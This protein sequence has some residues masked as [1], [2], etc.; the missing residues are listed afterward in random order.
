[1]RNDLLGPRTEAAGLGVDEEELLLHAEGE[2]IA[3]GHATGFLPWTDHRDPTKG[4][5]ELMSGR[6]VLD[7]LVLSDGTGQSPLPGARVVIDRITGASL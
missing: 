3:V 5:V 4:W 6:V 2:V 1:L 7:D